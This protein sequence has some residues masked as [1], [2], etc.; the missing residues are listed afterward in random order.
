MTTGGG[1]DEPVCARQNLVE[2]LTMIR[3]EGN[4]MIL[5]PIHSQTS[6]PAQ[7]RALNP[8]AERLA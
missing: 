2:K 6:Q 8:F 3:Q 5:E 4:E 1:I 7:P